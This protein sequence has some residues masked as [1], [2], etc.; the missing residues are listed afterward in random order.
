MNLGERIRAEQFVVWTDGAEQYA[1]I[2]SVR[3][4]AKPCLTIGTNAQG[5]LYDGF[6]ANF[7]SEA[8]C[9]RA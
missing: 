5:R 2:T 3:S 6:A 7:T 9:S 1:E 4:S 8:A